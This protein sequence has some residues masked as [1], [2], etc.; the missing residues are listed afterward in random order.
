MLT[1]SEESLSLKEG[2]AYPGFEGFSLV[3]R[4]KEGTR[5]LVFYKT[6]KCPRRLILFHHRSSFYFQCQESDALQSSLY[7]YCDFLIAHVCK[8]D[9]LKN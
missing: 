8:K 5:A 2:S 4:Y 3:T 7:N 6:Y 1:T 9:A